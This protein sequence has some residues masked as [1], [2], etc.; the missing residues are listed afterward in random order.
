MRT[1]QETHSQG[2][3]DTFTGKRLRPSQGEGVR[4]HCRRAALRMHSARFILTPP[5]ATPSDNPPNLSRPPEPEN[6]RSAEYSPALGSAW[7]RFPS[8]HLHPCP[9]L[10]SSR[11]LRFALSNCEYPDQLSTWDDPG[12]D[13]ARQSPLSLTLHLRCGGAA[14]SM[15]KSRPHARDR[16]GSCSVSPC[17]PIPCESQRVRL[18]P[19]PRP[20]SANVVPAVNAYSTSTAQ[21]NSVASMDLTRNL[22]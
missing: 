19:R 16:P 6:T 15:T 7:L 17:D 8:H 14:H 9:G 10:R 5:K 4:I 18:G 22:A 3:P 11:S 2:G 20:Y 21:S 12:R 1:R 13:N